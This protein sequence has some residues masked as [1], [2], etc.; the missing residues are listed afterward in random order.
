MP[1]VEVNRPEVLEELSEAFGRYEAALIGNDLAT[2]A[3]LFWD[4]PLAVRFGDGQN[5][6]GHDQIT[7]FRTARAADDVKRDLDRVVITTFGADV[8]TT[9]AEFRRV[10]SGTRGRQ[11]QTWVRT[12]GGWRIVAAHVSLLP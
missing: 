2:L 11:M 10:A 12:D 8:A 6:Y 9:S 7:A 5:L 1:P 4:S 3:E